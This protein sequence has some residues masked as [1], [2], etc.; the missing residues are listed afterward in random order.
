MKAVEAKLLAFLK[1]SP[2]FVIPIYQRT[3]SW[4]ERECRQLWN[5]IVKAGSNEKVNAHFIG[6]IVYVEKGLY[7]V[8]TQSP[9]LVIDGQQRLTTVSLLILAL[10]ES[11]GAE[12]PADGF[13]AKKLRNYYLV[14]P[15]EEGE[16]FFKLILSQTDKAT[17]TALVKGVELPTDVSLRIQENLALFKRYVA[18]ESNNLTSVCKGLAKLMVVDISLDR[19]Q[20]NPQLIFESM[21]STGLELSQADLIR[22]Y[23]LMGLDREPQEH[24]YEHY[25][26]PMEL[27]FGQ[28]AYSEEFDGFMRHYLTVKT[29]LI[30][31]V[32]HVYRLFKR[33]SQSPEVESVGVEALVKDIRIHAR[34][35]CAMALLK[36]TDADLRAAFKDLRE[37]KV[38]VA[39]PLML[40][41]YAD[42]DKGILPK[43][44]FLEVLRLLESYVFRR[45]VCEIPTNSM[46][47]TF[48]TF[49]KG[50]KK[51]S[52]LDSIKAQFLTLPS[53][54][55]FPKD[56]EFKKRFQ[57]RDLYNFRS[58]SYW[59]RRFENHG[60][61][62]PI[63]VEDF[64]I[65]HILPQ[66]ENLPNAWKQALGEDWAR[67]QGQYLHTLG[68]LTLTGYNS[69]YSNHAFLLKR[70]M[71]GGFKE[72]PLHVNK[73][74]G[75]LE[76]WN[77][78]TIL[79][80]ASTLA[81]RS[82]SVWPSPKLDEAALAGFLISK[83]ASAS[84]VYSIEQHP[85]VATGAMK[86]VFEAIRKEILAL[87]PCVTEEFLKLYI[88][89]KAETN[90]VDI[91]PQAKRLRLS[92]NI[93]FPELEDTKG[94][95]KD[96]TTLG[97]W[98][99]GDVELGV[100]SIDE[101][102]HAMGLIRQA[103]ERQLDSFKESAEEVNHDPG[104][105]LE[106]IPESPLLLEYERFFK[107][108][109]SLF[110][111][112]CPAARAGSVSGKHYHQI[113]TGTSGLHYEWGFHGKPR[114][115]I[116]IEL[117]FE[118]KDPSVNMARLEY[119]KSH[120]SEWRGW[121]SDVSNL[122]FMPTWGSVGWARMFFERPVG[123]LT[124]ELAEQV[125]ADMAG[126]YR[127]TA[128]Y[129]PALGSL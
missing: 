97:R 28:Q 5:D 85:Q 15:E 24:L 86:D 56:E 10:A 7:N 116:G 96:V 22:N 112:M 51:D 111:E 124:T 62:E 52:Y 121:L 20:D 63:H 125:A 79:Q 84:P 89:Y 99:N 46:N 83:A 115:R 61:K 66:S 48:V 127:A 42:Y 32:E 64:T 105:N 25:W 34:F 47:K 107:L 77:E 60:R 49:A 43:T 82:I 23:I 14:N 126:L 67:I 29:G 106:Q 74:L 114:D 54:R 57:E 100:S 27:E 81:D 21:N 12:E 98:G 2:Q 1:K 53:Y 110:I 120:E 55:R 39:F 122:T 128:G 101:I 73:G 95:A 76:T 92:I 104:G 8:S 117:H 45:A 123:A 68:N 18:E 88:A 36:E 119:L 41:L 58:K 93:P 6:S 75:Q 113:P 103:F 19:D 50:I 59:L 33:H 94:L 9:L 30:P 102:P 16:R 69:E 26:R 4:G 118:S 87:D 35:F 78:T 71:P 108:V 70:D 129:L 31:K 109:Q 44:Q 13:S 3:Y 37:L 90:F 65:E 40:E 72:S 38:E 80:R 17:L 91:V 11:V